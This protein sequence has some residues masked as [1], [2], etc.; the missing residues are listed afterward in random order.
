MGIN[1]RPPAALLDRLDQVFGITSPR[2]HGCTVVE[3]IESMLRGDIRVL[4]SLGGNFPVAAP[5][6]DQTYQA[7]TK[8]ALYVGIHTKLNRS[9]LLPTQDALILPALARSDLDVQSSGIQSV[10]VEDSMSMVHASRGFNK[11]SPEMRSEPYIVAGMAAS[12]L[13]GSP[14]PWRDLVTDYKRIRDYIA[15]VIP[16]FERFN[17]RLATPGGFHLRNAAAE[18]EWLTS[19]R[20][21]QFKT[22]GFYPTAS[23]LMLTTIRSHDQYNT[24]IYGFNDRYRGIEGRRDVLFMNEADIELRGFKAG[25]RVEVRSGER[26]LRGLTLVAYPITSGCCAAYYPE[27]NTLIDLNAIDRQSRTP[28]YKSIA[29][30][31]IKLP[32]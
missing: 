14:I 18:R 25:D 1:E 29:V 3:C 17:E 12:T 32:D 26:R 5:D 23:P 15:R 10:S 28:A 9:H 2:D 30:D 7:M 20:R 19:T 22:M 13:L 4:V 11:P 8:L 27:A 16:G 21:A 6:P 24:T 31:I